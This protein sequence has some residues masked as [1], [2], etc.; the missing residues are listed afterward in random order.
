MDKALMELVLSQGVFASLFVWLLFT[1]KK[2]SKEREVKYQE[3]IKE[4]AES[5]REI[6]DKIN[7]VEKIE[8]DVE[9]IKNKINNK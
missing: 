1:T 2:D 9:E 3:V 5:N 6:A 7:I 4:L 8:E